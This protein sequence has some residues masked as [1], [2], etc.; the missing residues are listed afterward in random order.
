MLEK[1]KSRPEV[2]F[3]SDG[4]VAERL[5]TKTCF[6]TKCLKTDDQKGCQSF[7][8]EKK[9]FFQFDLEKKYLFVVG[10]QFVSPCCSYR[11]RFEKIGCLD[12]VLP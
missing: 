11:L 8:F 12:I 5:K 9:M 4:I 10:F 2:G 6:E 7:Q 1:D 3:C